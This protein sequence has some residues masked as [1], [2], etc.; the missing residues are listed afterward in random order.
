MN[1]DQTLACARAAHEVNR[2]YCMV[3]GDTSQQ[4]WDD[5]PNW[6]KVSVLNGVE[7]VLRGNSPEQS[8]DLWLA[9]KRHEGWRYGPVKDPILQEHPCF[10]PY[11][12]LPPEQKAKDAL[13]VSVVQAMITALGGDQ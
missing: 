10:L 11:A 12:E 7:G 8:H 2:A 3:L 5:A 9:G 6:Q 13:F 1:Y 4:P